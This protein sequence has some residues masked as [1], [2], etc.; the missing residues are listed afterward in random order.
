MATYTVKDSESGKTVTFKWNSPQPP[1]DDDMSEVFQSVKDTLPQQTESTATGGFVGTA[2]PKE[3]GFDTE[4]YIRPALEY[5]GMTAGSVLGA[6]AGPA[7]AIAGAG[8]LYGAGKKTADILYN[9]PQGSVGDELLGSAVDVSQGAAM[10]MLGPVTG[11]LITKYGKPAATTMY[12]NTR[13]A[14]EKAIRPGVAKQRTAGQAKEYFDKAADAVTSIV[15]NK[16][17]LQLTNESGK[18]VSG[19]PKTLKQFSDSIQQTKQVIFEQYDKM[20][21][22][23]AGGGA[24]VSLLPAAKELDVILQSKPLQDMAPEAVKY[25]ESRIAALVAR[26][27]YTPAEAQ[28]AIKILNN[29][30]K[31]F[32]KNPSYET[33]TKAYIDSLV[34]NNVRRSLDDAVSQIS[35]PGYQSLKNTYGALSEI[36]NDVAHRAAIDARKNIKGLIDFSDIFSGSEAIYGIL[37][38]N[39]AVIARGATAK[40]ISGYY[41]YLNNPNR[42]VGRMFQSA[43]NIINSQAGRTI[44]SSS[45]GRQMAAKAAGYGLSKLDDE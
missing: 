40:A 38:M 13:T 42:I 23:A 5:G 20:Q 25:A 19:L 32:Y 28:N 41:R 29:S 34:A 22:L 37:T 12:K 39:P 11:R 17:N 14:I 35:G 30:L 18:K 24:K 31:A 45:T 10:E 4:P 3:V 27:Q 15:L 36:E 9:K 44:P 16:D 33:A 21:S 26:K 1:T 6:G 2:L 43:E 8:L 7:G